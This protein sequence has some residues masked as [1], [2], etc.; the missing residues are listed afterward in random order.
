MIVEERPKP[1]WDKLRMV[2]LW[3]LLPKL[4]ILIHFW[5]FLSEKQACQLL[6][7]SIQNGNINSHPLCNS[8]LGGIFSFFFFFFLGILS[9]ISFLDFYDFNCSLLNF[10][11]QALIFPEAQGLEAQTVLQLKRSN[12]TSFPPVKSSMKNPSKT[13]N[14]SK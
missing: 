4:N 8:F 7:Y 10:K 1:T 9:I 5:I 6:S 12:A 11:L 2:I 13:S 14:K 3:T